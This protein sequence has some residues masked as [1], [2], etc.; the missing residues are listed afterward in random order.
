MDASAAPGV[1]P[2]LA[3]R[4]KEET[5]RQ[6]SIAYRH[7]EAHAI[8]SEMLCHGRGVAEAWPRPGRTP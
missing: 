8:T 1:S 2:W 5:P 6:P 7:I 4:L 3:S